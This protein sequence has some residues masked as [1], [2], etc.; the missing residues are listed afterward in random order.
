MIVL[1]LSL[2][3]VCFLAHVILLFTS[4]GA[5]GVKRTRYFLSHL[6][7]WLTG[8]FAYLTALLYA[9]KNISAVID[10]FDTPGKQLLLLVVAFGLSLVA[11]SIVKLFVL[12]QHK[13]A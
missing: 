6:T 10:M 8:A 11:H 4:F 7:L 12:P 3:A 5:G 9:G 13:R 1:L 2:M